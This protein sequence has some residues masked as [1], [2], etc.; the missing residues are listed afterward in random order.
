M[1]SMTAADHDE[2]ETKHRAA[3]K[4][5]T[6]PGSKIKHLRAAQAHAEASKSLR[7]K[8]SNPKFKSRKDVSLSEHAMNLSS[9][10]NGSAGSIGLP[11]RLP[12]AGL[13]NRKGNPMKFS[14]ALSRIL[15]KGDVKDDEPVAGTSREAAGDTPAT[16]S[17]A[18]LRR[19]SQSAK[20]DLAAEATRHADALTAEASKTGSVDAHGHAAAW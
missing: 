17:A 12:L 5:A 18:Q 15:G 8:K 13:L 7:G 6:D 14:E 20:E 16:A 4:T 19:M 9:Q 1:K 2:M 3:I 10:A 11:S